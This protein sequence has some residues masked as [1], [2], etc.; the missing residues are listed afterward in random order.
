MKRILFALAFALVAAGVQYWAFWDNG[1]STFDQ[2]MVLGIHLQGFAP[3]LGANLLGL[4]LLVVFDHVKASRSQ[5]RTPRA[6]MFSSPH[7]AA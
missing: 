7:V 6:T 5:H 2:D 4:T 1:G 3:C